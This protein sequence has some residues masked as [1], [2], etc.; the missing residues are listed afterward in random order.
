MIFPINAMALDEV[1]TIDNK[2]IGITI[3]MFDYD[4]EDQGDTHERLKH[5]HRDRVFRLEE[6]DRFGMQ[7]AVNDQSA[8]EG[9]SQSVQGI[10]Y[11]SFPDDHPAHHKAGQQPQ[12]HSSVISAG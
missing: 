3:N 4:A 8:M 6:I 11:S 9:E 5:V 10:Q 2:S 7:L 12:R 1:K